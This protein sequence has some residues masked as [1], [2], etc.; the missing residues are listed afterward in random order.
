MY[1]T[2]ISFPGKWDGVV[3]SS[4]LDGSD[5]RTLV[6]PGKVNTPKQLTL[7]EITG[8]IY[9][10]DREGLGVYRYNIDGWEFE[11]LVLNGEPTTRIAVA[12][13]LGKFF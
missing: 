12:P 11:C 13:S 5:V 2:C 7:D 10:S 1:W 4:A 6:I 3:Y 8:K 9:F